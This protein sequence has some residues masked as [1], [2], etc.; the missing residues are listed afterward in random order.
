MR[1]VGI[2]LCLALPFALSAC[3]PAPEGEP[4][5]RTEIGKGAEEEAAMRAEEERRDQAALAQTS[6]CSSV[7]FESVPLTHCIAD[8][9]RHRIRTA[10]ADNE[11]EVF[12]SL[13]SF[14]QTVDQ[15][16]IAFAVNGGEFERGGRP[17]GY[18]VEGGERLV[19]LDRQDG[20][21]NFYLK[22]NGVFYGTGGAW[23]IKSADRFYSTVGA[24]PQFGTQSGPML[25]IDGELH[26]EIQDN[27]PSRAVRNGVGIDAGGRAHFVMSEAALSFGQLARF[28]RDELKTPNA[29]YLDSNVSSLWNP[30]TA[31]LD[32]EAALGPLIV[33][34]NDDVEQAEEAGE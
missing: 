27:G 23:E 24:R 22:P 19:E 26:P 3:E 14:S 32:A 17:I 2:T 10:L 12:G 1:S 7:E 28:F 21:G 33:V 9:A 18:Y 5:T 30:A 4:V 15:A 6:V 11:G 8:P 13:D 29:L 25:V 34:L 16:T 31:R 20:S